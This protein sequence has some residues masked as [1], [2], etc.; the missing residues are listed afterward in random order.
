MGKLPDRFFYKWSGYDATKGEVRTMCMGHFVAPVWTL[1]RVAL[2]NSLTHLHWFR[3]W[4][5]ALKQE[6]ERMWMCASRLGHF[7]VPVWQKWA[8]ERVSLFH[9]LTHPVLELAPPALN[10]DEN[11]SAD[12]THRLSCYQLKNPPPKQLRSNTAEWELQAHSVLPS[13]YE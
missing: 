9:P 3:G 8:F 6:L 4:G 2:S 7:V 1:E 5:D 12:V 13:N 11:V 10:Q